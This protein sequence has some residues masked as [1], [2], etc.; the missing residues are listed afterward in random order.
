MS[1]ILELVTAEV[2]FLSDAFQHIPEFWCYEPTLPPSFIQRN[3][4]DLKKKYFGIWKSAP[5]QITVHTN[6]PAAL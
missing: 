6:I 4:Q 2:T 1:M 5:A 3:S